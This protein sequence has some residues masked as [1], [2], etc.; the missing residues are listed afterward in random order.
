MVATELLAA[1]RKIRY[2]QRSQIS[3]AVVEVLVNKKNAQGQAGEQQGWA[4]NKRSIQMLELRL[5]KIKGVRLD[6]E[7]L[8]TWWESQRQQ[9]CS[10]TDIIKDLFRNALFEENNSFFVFEAIVPRK[11]SPMKPKPNASSRSISNSPTKKKPRDI[12]II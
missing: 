3:K 12:Y 6:K 10:P 9:E 11:Q 7:H 8:M 5:L 2:H 4:W 1:K